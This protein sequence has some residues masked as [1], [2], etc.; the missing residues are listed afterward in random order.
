MVV[1]SQM[2]QV[3]FLSLF[4]LGASLPQR[5]QGPEYP[6]TEPIPILRQESEVN[7]DGTYK[8]SYETG[9][10]ISHEESGFLKDTGDPENQSQVVQGSSSYTSPEGIQ[11]KLVYVADEFGFQPT[12]DH[13]PVKPPTPVLIQKALDYLAT[14]PSTPEPP[15][16]SPSRR[17]Y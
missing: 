8:Y 12:G 10:G 4:T 14:L 11:I 7:F 1:L 15:V 9:N 16:V 2:L 17:Y 13:L 5:R 3:L 6:A